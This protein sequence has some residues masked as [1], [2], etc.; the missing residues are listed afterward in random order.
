MMNWRKPTRMQCDSRRSLFGYDKAANSLLEK[1][2]VFYELQCGAISPEEMSVCLFEL[3]AEWLDGTETD[4][5]LY[6]REDDLFP[7]IEM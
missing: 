3:F 6:H 5:V 7:M 4:D 2:E 1:I